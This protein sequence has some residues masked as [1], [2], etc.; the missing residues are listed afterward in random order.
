MTHLQTTTIRVPH[1]ILFDKDGTLIDFNRSWL[2]VYQ[3]AADLLAQRFD[4][5]AL[6]KNLM[7]AGGYCYDSGTWQHNGQRVRRVP[8]CADHDPHER[9]YRRGLAGSVAR[10]RSHDHVGQREFAELPFCS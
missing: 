2:P 10:V 5:P 1:G 8:L 3:Q 7:L 6:A 9:R 4:D